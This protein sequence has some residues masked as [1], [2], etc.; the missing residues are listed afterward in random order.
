MLIR[1]VFDWCYKLSTKERMDILRVILQ[2]APSQPVKQD[3]INCIFYTLAI[4]KAV[5]HDYNAKYKKELS[6]LIMSAC[7][8]L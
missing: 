8:L 4:I 1:H 5:A 2:G 7:A 3:W 6:S